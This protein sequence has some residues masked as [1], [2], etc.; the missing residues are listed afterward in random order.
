MAL[1][2]K[3]DSVLQIKEAVKNL[4]DVANENKS[5]SISLSMGLVRT[6]LKDLL[7][8]YEDEPEAT[9]KIDGLKVSVEN[10]SIILEQKLY[11]ECNLYGDLVEL[12]RFAKSMYHDVYDVFSQKVDNGTNEEILTWAEYVKFS[13]IMYSQSKHIVFSLSEDDENM[14]KRITMDLKA[15]KEL[16]G[17]IYE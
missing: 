4:L 14:I 7:A 3:T 2:E 15:F 1:K 16:G 12:R 6:Y 13:L 10:A 8:L 17:I 9:F 11:H 5:M